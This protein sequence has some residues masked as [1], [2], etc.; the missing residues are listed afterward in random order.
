[1]TSRLNGRSGK[2][3]LTHSTTHTT[4]SHDCHTPEAVVRPD[5]PDPPWTGP[6][7]DPGAVSLPDHLPQ[8]GPGRPGVRDDLGGARRP[9]NVPDRAGANRG[10]RARLALHLPGRDLPRGEPPRL[11]LQTR[12]RADGPVRPDRHPGPAPQGE[13]SVAALR[14]ED[15]ASR[16]NGRR[17]AVLERDD[18]EFLLA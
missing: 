2:L 18:G 6:K 8:P 7:A 16:L 14:S 9:R 17:K 3:N 12:A 10:R 4:H 1:L 15:S 5:H 13:R 11:P